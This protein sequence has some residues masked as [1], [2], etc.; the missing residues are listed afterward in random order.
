MVSSTGEAADPARLDAVIRDALTTGET[1]F[2]VDIVRWLDGNRHA[3]PRRCGLSARDVIVLHAEERLQPG[4]LV[5]FEVRPERA[6]QDAE[7]D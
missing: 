3:Y 5:V 1:T 4:D 6:I 7:T 2:E